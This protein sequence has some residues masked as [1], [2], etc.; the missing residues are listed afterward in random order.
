MSKPT[1]NLAALAAASLAL[2]GCETV[3]EPAAR[4][5]EQTYTASLLGLAEVPGPGDPDGS[6]VADITI[7][8]D[9]NRICYEITVTAMAPATAA[10]IHRGTT[11]E[12]GPPVVTLEVP[13][14]GEV[15]GCVAAPDAVADLIAANPAGYYVNIHNAEYPGGA[16]RGQLHR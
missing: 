9:L 13:V 10:H 7:V 4:A 8:D 16:I 1:I 3:A 15:S 5:M 11:G 6:G 2:S 14:N 12:A